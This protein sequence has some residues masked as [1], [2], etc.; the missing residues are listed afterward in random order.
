MSIT[1]QP[2]IDFIIT[3]HQF[4][5]KSPDKSVR[6]WDKKTPYSIHPVWCA[7]T[8]LTETALPKNIR[9]NGV[10][11]LLY[12]DVLEDTNVKLPSTLKPLIIKY[13]RDMTFSEGITQEMEEIWDKPK[14]I[15][16]FKLY[17]KVSNL[18]DATWMSDE[19][20][21]KYREYT[22]RLMRDVESNYGNLNI[23][24]LARVMTADV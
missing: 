10:L 18:L 6:L 5:S 17:D 22:A 13:I 14:E 19:L 8:I 3:A 12:H 9:V 7:M 11:T 15:R 24:K 1:L 16:L 4:H 23:V 20:K 2:H 21:I